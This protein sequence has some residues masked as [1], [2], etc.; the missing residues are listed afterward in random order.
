MQ[1]PFRH[2]QA[3]PPDALIPGGI[4]CP[5]CYADQSCGAATQEPNHG[6]EI[7]STDVTFIQFL[8][9]YLSREALC[10]YHQAPA[11]PMRET[12]EFGFVRYEALKNNNSVMKQP[13]PDEADN[14]ISLKLQRAAC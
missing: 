14:A 13:T 8:N 10:I 2:P 7:A 4:A 3:N 11:I 9:C 12:P 1:F 5:E 6:E